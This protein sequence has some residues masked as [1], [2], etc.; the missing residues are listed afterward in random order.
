[1]ITVRKALAVGG[2]VAALSATALPI[3]TAADPG[4]EA[5]FLDLLNAERTAAGLNELYVHD[6]LLDDARSHSQVM[7]DGDFLH[8]NP[9]LASVTEGWWRL[10]ENVGV[11]PD[12][13]V[14]HEAFMNSEG[15][16]RNI[17]GEWDYV[18]IGVQVE[19][20]YK[21]WVTVVFMEAWP[22]EPVDPEPE[23]APAEVAGADLPA[24]NAATVGLV[25]P[26]TG[27]WHLQDANGATTSFYYGNPGDYPMTGDWD[28][29]GIDTPG[30]YRQSDGYVYLRN[31]N[32]PGIADIRFYFGNPSDVPLAGD[33]D[34]DGCDSV[35]LYRP[36]EG[37]VYVINR[38]GS[39]DRGLG[40]AD[41]HY[42]FG[43]AGEVPV[44]GD[45]DG[46]GIDTVAMHDAAAARA[47]IRNGHSADA[48][49]DTISFGHAGDRAVAGDW[50]GDR[51]ATL[52]AYRPAGRDFHVDGAT[53]AGTIAPDGART[54]FLPIAGRFDA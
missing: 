1:M 27:I 4:I 53:T 17:M 51:V 49:E 6:D 15:H 34:G 9:D 20:E 11:G 10:G 40:A 38:L 42:P 14:L 43:R 48:P 23:P 8:H 31:S 32:T 16:R 28:C 45:F 39:E 35:S 5:E 25:D 33:F 13:P 21:I 26:A 50:T 37:E 30:L 46:D 29:D 2:L 3:A 7:L 24:S 12:A 52:G 44:T 54:T 19:S 41:Y 18:G 47:R 36:S 22:G